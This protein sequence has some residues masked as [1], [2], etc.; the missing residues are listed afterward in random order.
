VQRRIMRIAT[1]K[2][3][4]KLVP[5]LGLIVGFAVN[6]LTT[7]AIGHAADLWYRR[8]DGR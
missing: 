7:R 5:G 4:A 8:T 6:Y 2:A 3:A 1:E